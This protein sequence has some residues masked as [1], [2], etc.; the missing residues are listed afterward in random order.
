MN[1]LIF[2]GLA[3]GY[4]LIGVFILSIINAASAGE[5]DS[6]WIMILWPFLIV[7]GILAAIITGV[8]KAGEFI[9]DKIYDKLN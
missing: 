5:I 4:L 7:A 6:F 9:G 2:T 3:I 1:T 8:I